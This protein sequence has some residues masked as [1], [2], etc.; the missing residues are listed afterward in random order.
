V[1]RDRR[2]AKTKAQFEGILELAHQIAALERGLP[3]PWRDEWSTHVA[4]LGA[5]DSPG[6]ALVKAAK[7]AAANPGFYEDEP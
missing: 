2:I 6:A 3:A 7:W 1:T 5:W 4:E